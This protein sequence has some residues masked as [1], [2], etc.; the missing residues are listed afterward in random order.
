MFQTSEG[1]IDIVLLLELS[2]SQSKLSLLKHNF[3]TFSEMRRLI[4]KGFFPYLSAMK[5]NRIQA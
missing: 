5:I 2:V 4:A 3:P 1:E